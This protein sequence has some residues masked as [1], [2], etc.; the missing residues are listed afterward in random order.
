M[1]IQKANFEAT[2]FEVKA[3]REK[4]IVEAEI[5]KAIYEARRPEIYLA[6][7]QKEIAAIIYP[8]LMGVQVTMPHNI[9]T[10]GGDKD[11]TLL[12][13]FDV[14]SSFATLGVMEQLQ[15][16]SISRDKSKPDN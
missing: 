13:N 11:N 16:L 9:I 5:L 2:Q 14:L 8:N 12:T 1:Q 6:E 15:G 10:L 4:G 7:I 3:I